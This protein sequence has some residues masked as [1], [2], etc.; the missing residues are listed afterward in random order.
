MSNALLQGLIAALIVGGI[1]LV[2]G[3]Y[4]QR[5]QAKNPHGRCVYCGKPLAMMG[6]YAKKCPHCKK[7]QPRVNEGNPP[8]V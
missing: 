1:V 2:L 7:M 3:V 5:R 4:M 8:V 6:P